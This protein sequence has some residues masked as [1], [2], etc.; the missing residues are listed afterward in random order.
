MEYEAFHK[1]DRFAFQTKYL[2]TAEEFT[3][4]LFSVCEIVGSVHNKKLQWG[5]LTVL[6]LFSFWEIKIIKKKTT[7]TNFFFQHLDFSL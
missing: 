3:N 1:E 7:T 4:K 5:R 6:K 2:I